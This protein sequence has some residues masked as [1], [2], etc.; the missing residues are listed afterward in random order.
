MRILTKIIVLLC[1]IL[2]VC[3][4][5]L[6]LLVHS[7]RLRAKALLRDEQQM[8]EQFFD[9]LA[10]LKGSSLEMFTTDYT[11]W[12]EMVRFLSTGDRRWASA[13]IDTALPTYQASVAWVFRTDF[14]LVYSVNTL[15]APS[16]AGLPV[17]RDVLNRLFGAGPFP[18][19][20]L[21]TPGG[22]LEIR[23]APIQPSSDHNRIT[24]PRGYFLAGRIWND[25]YIAELEELSGLTIQVTDRPQAAM[26]SFQKDIK[27]SRTLRGWDET[28]VRYITLHRNSDMEEGFTLASR[29]QFLLLVVFSLTL[30]VGL[31]IFLTRWVSHPLRLL[32]RG[33]AEQNPEVV[34]RL[35]GDVSEFGRLARL[36][37]DFMEQKTA[38]SKEITERQ[39]VEQ[40]LR[41]SEERY[42]LAAQ[43]ANEG[44][45]DWNVEKNEMYFSPRWKSALG[46]EDHEV[47][48][49]PHEWF[50]RIHPDDIERVHA[51]L[52]AH[53]GG[54][55]PLFECEHRMRSRDGS[56]RWVLSRGI[57]VRDPSGNLSRIAGSQTDITDRMLHD[58]LTGLPNRALF[59]DRLQHAVSRAQRHPEYVFAVMLLDLD[60]FKLVNESLG[61]ATGDRLLI[62]TARRLEAS[63]R[64]SD[65]V[66]R[67]GS[68]EFVLLIEDVPD[69][70]ESLHVAD[71]L[72][73]TLAQPFML[74]GD[75][76]YATGTIGIALS[77]LGYERVD[78]LLRDVEIALHRAKSVGPSKREV[79][80]AGMHARAVNRLKLETDLRG[81]LERRELLLY[82]QPIVASPLRHIV[83][84]ESLLRWAHPDRG[85]VSPT[86]FIPV[87]EETGLIIPIGE[88]VLQEAC[89]QAHAW[90]VAYPSIEPVMI[91]V[92]LSGK[93]FARPDLIELIHNVLRETR[94]APDRLKIELTESV[95]MDSAPLVAEVLGRLK[96][97]GVRISLDD[98][99]T[100]YSSLGYLH[101]FPIDTLKIDRS[102]VLTIPQPGERS[103]I[104]DA[105]VTLAHGLGMEV[106]AEG[107]ESPEQMDYLAALG[108]E[109][110][111]GFYFSRPLPANE[112]A[113]LLTADPPWLAAA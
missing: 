27:F 76:V 23:G 4:L 63:L 73:A 94:L 46:Y 44:L 19:F 77:V 39:R 33:L 78:D 32:S 70:S 75:E 56:Y 16:L 21:V 112:A 83:G 67:L 25:A 42:A 59:R 57:A 92:N 87:A 35:R 20:F 102:F 100:G 34:H 95:L 36:I 107:V 103:P 45:W 106:T 22:L 8:E 51:A 84:F 98:F 65:T 82:Y 66:A 99:G 48:H 30:I 3:F 81:A 111:Q 68:D 37:Q 31:T 79:F 89:R 47:E 113:V 101:R 10:R 91:S 1:V 12:D 72:Q 93:Q 49:S 24:A 69:A 104:V 88:W 6:S 60:G 50:T 29:Q 7:E 18:H 52:S 96:A 109:T 41:E 97:V 110:L 71:R 62:E 26:E 13:I 105:I 28:P 5:A 85:L 74:D 55:T 9:R 15:N 40:A 86:E 14:S 2:S 61:H 11:Y 108:C 43:G 54:T 17:P 38:L 90:H 53:Q 80:N 64:A 58:A